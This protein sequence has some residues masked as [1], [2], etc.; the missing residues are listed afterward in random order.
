M[1]RLILTFLPLFP[2]GPRV[3]GQLYA[4]ESHLD[5]GTLLCR[6]F[7]SIG[8]QS[9]L[10]AFTIIPA[11]ECV[12]G[13]KTGRGGRGDGRVIFDLGGVV[14]RTNLV[15][16][17]AVNV[18]VVVMVVMGILVVVVVVVGVVGCD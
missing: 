8:E 6:A 16:I 10:R 4:P 11:G 17:R 9:V 2:V 18:V 15:V 14:V 1:P 3:G 13:G 5:Y 12:S 7:N